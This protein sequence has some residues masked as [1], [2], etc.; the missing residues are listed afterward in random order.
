[1]PRRVLIAVAATLLAWLGA[2]VPAASQPICTSASPDCLARIDTVHQLAASNF[3][4]YLR[5]YLVSYG[6][7]SGNVTLNDGA[8]GVF[9]QATCP[10]GGGADGGSILQDSVSHCFYRQNLNGDLRQWGLIRGSNYDVEYQLAQAI[11]S[12][13]DASGQIAAAFKALQTAS[14]TSAYLGIRELHTRGITL[15]IGTTIQIPPGL[16]LTCDTPPVKR[17]PNANYARLPGSLMLAHV[18]THSNPVFIDAN[19]YGAGPTDDASIHDCAAIVPEWYVIPSKVSD[20]TGGISFNSPTSPLFQYADLEAIRANMVVAS[21]FAIATGLGAKIHDL[22]IVGFDTCINSNPSEDFMGQNIWMD[23]SVGLYL[24]TSGGI[25]NVKD[26]DNNPFLTKQP[27]FANEQYWNITGIAPDATSN[28]ECQLSLSQANPLFPVSALTQ[29][30]TDDG[31]TP[32]RRGDPY[33][34]PAWV[35]VYEKG[36]LS[37]L[38]SGTG[39]FGNDVGWAVH[40]IVPTGMTTATVDLL[41]SKYTDT[42]ST[43]NITTH[44]DWNAN[45][46]VLRISD[47]IANL[48]PGMTVTSPDPS[49]P[50]SGTTVTVSGIVTRC[51]GPDMTDGYNACVLVT[52]FPKANSASRATLIFN[53]PGPFTAKTCDGKGNGTCMYYNSQERY[54][55]GTSPGGT[56]SARLPASRGG[57]LGAGF[58]YDNVAGVRGINA[59]SYGHYY[60]TVAIDA[61]DCH[62]LQAK[63]DENG[64]LNTGSTIGLYVTGASRGCDFIG[65]GPGK[66]ANDLVQDTYGISDSTLPSITINPSMLG[67][68]HTAIYTGVSPAGW[69][70]IGEVHICQHVTMLGACRLTMNNEYAA[71][72]FDSTASTLTIYVRGRFGT[73]PVD[74]SMISSATLIPALVNN[75]ATNGLANQQTSTVFDDLA[76]VTNVASGSKFEVHHGG[77]TFTNLHVQQG[78]N[79][80]VSANATG[81]NIVTSSQPGVTIFY[82]N[83]AARAGTTISPDSQFASYVPQGAINQPLSYFQQF[84]SPQW[85]TTLSGLGIAS[86]GTIAVQNTK[87]WP[88]TGVVLADTEYMAYHIV[89]GTDISIDQRG[90]CGSS[91]ANHSVFGVF[92]TY[93]NVLY[94]CPPLSQGLPQLTMDSTGA[95]AFAQSALSHGQ[96]YMS[97]NG[98]NIQLCPSGGKGLIISGKMRTIPT[99]CTIVPV[100]TASTINTVYYVYATYTQVAV[101]Q[102]IATGTPLHA[103]LYVP[104]VPG[105]PNFYQGTPVTCYGIAG[106][107]TTNVIEDANT[108]TG[109]DGTGLY[110]DLL[111]VLLPSGPGPTDNNGACSYI[112]LV[113]DGTFGHVTDKFGVEVNSNGLTGAAET[114]VGAVH[115]DPTGVVHDTA[116]IRDVA[117]WFNRKTK[118]CVATWGAT[119]TVT[120]SSGLFKQFTASS[121]P[122]YCSFLTWSQDNLTWSIFGML[123][124][125]QTSEVA[126][127]SGGFDGITPPTEVTQWTQTTAGQRFP[128]NLT[129]SV[130]LSE[131]EHYINLIGEA[132]AGNLTMY[133]TAA[134]N[135]TGGEEVRIPQ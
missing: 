77:A 89:D 27:G 117:S 108:N 66:P 100:S 54:V 112:G 50:P 94:G 110:I 118:T 53:S 5:I 33:Y 115:T 35:A 135:L 20:L 58:I 97:L 24:A 31:L 8:D 90:L 69:P 76:N 61:A 91:A 18:D 47:T 78:G 131:G 73:A 57:H 92:V 88:Q 45:T 37:C 7:S 126:A 63:G 55:S 40:N 130:S 2:V 107:P 101:T 79:G 85:T 81:V 99:P 14:M 23:C 119:A 96:A 51:T 19:T 62:I 28:N 103:R 67:N 104:T 93:M 71:Y 121:S 32:P 44:G 3:G 80:F 65:Q 127:V 120:G 106:T 29:S 52:P 56:D 17:S 70:P 1:M 13:S 48:A 6:D 46:G 11:P 84:G 43:Y 132:P 26:F 22:T 30:K 113:T 124:D 75:G 98:A 122:L 42:T 12:I 39:Q 68:Y 134:G 83:T 133:F 21:D 102:I 82:E 15:K 128:A 114:L 129:G 9:V 72:V 109:S 95:V 59:F 105:V 25:S 87:Y 10:A 60:H 16:S 36:P 4:S 86:L 74:W 41:H 49:W 38:S 116:L 64:E 34:Y 125:S 123:G 111:D